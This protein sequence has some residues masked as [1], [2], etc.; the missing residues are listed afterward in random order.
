M[1]LDLFRD[2]FS[3][4]PSRALN[5]FSEAQMTDS[6]YKLLSIGEKLFKSLAWDTMVDVELA[7]LYSA[8]PWL[9]PFSFLI[10][11]IVKKFADALFDRFRLVIDLGAIVF[12]SAAHKAAY[13]KA[14]VSLKV[15]AIDKGEESDDYKKARD[16]AKKELSA[17]ASFGGKS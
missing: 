9:S 6:A 12:V 13:D 2:P 4:F 17:F 3:F 14:S 10:N 1:D 15:L 8:A 11:F 5:S 16:Q 7:A